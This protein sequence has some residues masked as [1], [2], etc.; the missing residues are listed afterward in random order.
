MTR[1]MAVAAA[2]ACVLLQGADAAD[3]L[4]PAR[5]GSLQCYGPHM[6]SKTCSAL[7]GYTFNDDGT[8]TDQASVMV[9][10]DQFIV[11]KTNS[12]VTIKGDAVCG[13]L[14]KADIAAAKIYMHGQMMSPDEAIQ[15][16]MQLEAVMAPRFDKEVCTTYQ[17]YND[18]FY[19]HVT[20]DG[21]PD[22]GSSDYVLWVKPDDG[23][24]VAP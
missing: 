19:A 10:P 15:V 21:V 12:P 6:V 17:P 24:K 20:I 22:P 18:K 9:S 3:P 11:M 2:A 14:R 5:A 13:A 23:Y 4:A 8:I 7:A 1:A 16:R